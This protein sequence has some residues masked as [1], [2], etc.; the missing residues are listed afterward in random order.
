MILRPTPGC[1]SGENYNSKRYMHPCVHYSTI[2]NSPDME[3][4]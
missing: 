2:Y 3:T 1:G 4:D